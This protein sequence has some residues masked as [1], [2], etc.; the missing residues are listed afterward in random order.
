[1]PEIF[2]Y[3]S[4]TVETVQKYSVYYLYGILKDLLN[5]VHKEEDEYYSMPLVSE[6]F[7][8]FYDGALTK[9]EILLKKN[10]IYK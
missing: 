1:M 7:P 8:F 2:F 3:V 5:V 9:R 10:W 6:F 4:R